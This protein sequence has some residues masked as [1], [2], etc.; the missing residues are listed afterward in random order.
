MNCNIF[1]YS[2]TWRHYLRH[3]FKWWRETIRNFKAAWRR[4]IKG[5]CHTDCWEFGY[6]FLEVVPD[7]LDYLADHGKAYPGNDKFPT[8]ES[9]AEHLHLIAALLRNARDDR[10]D[11][12]NEYYPAYQRMV[13]NGEDSERW[14]DEQGHTHVRW[15]PNELSRNY[16]RK[17]EELAIEQDKIIEKALKLLAETPLKALWD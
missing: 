10:R 13:D 9:W 4:A 7:M 12:Q 14:T 5:W 16:F 3:P 6:W 1:Q 15:K 11:M 17:D 8:P 2:Y